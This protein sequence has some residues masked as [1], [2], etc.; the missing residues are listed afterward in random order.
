M[1]ASKKEIET[2]LK[3]ALKEVGEIKPWFDKE[4]NCWVFE[5]DHYPVVCG[6]DSKE[7]V[8]AKYPLYLKEF[9]KHRLENLL[10]PFVEKAT[11]GRGGARVGAGRPKKEEKKPT[12]TIRLSEDL[13]SAALWMRK[14]PEVLPEIQRIIQRHP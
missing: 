4:V 2:H 1:A 6:E 11:K 10:D 13:Y 5:H 8:I 7:E 3:R 9:I 14:H 12:K